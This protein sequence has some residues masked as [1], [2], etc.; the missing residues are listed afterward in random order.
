MHKKDSND[1]QNYIFDKTSSPLPDNYWQK[2]R[3][4][5][6]SKIIFRHHIKTVRLMESKIIAKMA[7]VS[8]EQKSRKEFGR[9]V[10]S[11]SVSDSK[12]FL[13]PASGDNKFIYEP[14][15]IE[16]ICSEDSTSSS[17]A[18]LNNRGKSSWPDISCD[19]YPVSTFEKPLEI[20][21]GP[22]STVIR[23][24]VQT[25]WRKTVDGFCRLFSFGHPKTRR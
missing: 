17:S 2:S 5:D 13:T 4:K 6:I 25:A 12:N 15:G 16:I 21:P 24:S 22:L 3:F 11:T 14:V 20:N 7:N 10:V 23:R 18:V 19:K 8:D 1:N 9:I